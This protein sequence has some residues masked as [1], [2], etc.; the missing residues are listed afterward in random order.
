MS[1]NS[2]IPT[3]ILQKVGTFTM[4]CTLHTVDCLC[5]RP[6]RLCE[7]DFALLRTHLKA[8]DCMKDHRGR[9]PRRSMSL[10]PHFSFCPGALNLVAP[11]L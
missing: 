4:N 5:P 7:G 9:S 11:T 1:R 10:E 6:V 8:E 3:K 2:K